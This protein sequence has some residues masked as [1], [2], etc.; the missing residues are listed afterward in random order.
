MPRQIS[1]EEYNFLQGRRQIADFSES[2]YNDPALSNDL[3]ALI[4]RKHPNLQIADYDLEQKFE[5]RLAEDRRQREE[6][7]AAEH[8]Q[9]EQERF[10][11]IRKKTQEQYGFTPEAMEELEKFMVERNVGDYDVAAK[12]IAAQNPKPSEATFR[13]DR[14][15]HSNAPGFA[16]IAKD[17]EEWARK[18]IMKS[19]YNDTE[20]QKNQRF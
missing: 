19:I 6:E 18:E 5:Q 9:Q 4:K 11:N 17:P 8:N 16:E 2:L 13:D 14:W 7:K 10:Q 12:Y 20:R 3:K 15:N 1:D